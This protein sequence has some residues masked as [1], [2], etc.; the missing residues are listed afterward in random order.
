MDQ[1]RKAQEMKWGICR[2]GG[3]LVCKNG[4][5]PLAPS[6][7]ATMPT[8]TP[9]SDSKGVKKFAKPINLN[10]DL[11]RMRPEALLGRRRLRRLST[12]NGCG[13]VRC[14]DF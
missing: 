1:S 3:L 14:A 6:A 7:F 4:L 8:G 5:S 11:G 13:S 9:P 10:A 12:G 2:A